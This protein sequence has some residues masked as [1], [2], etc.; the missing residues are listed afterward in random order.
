MAPLQCPTCNGPVGLADTNST[1]T[2]SDLPILVIPYL[3]CYLAVC[4]LTDIPD[5]KGDQSSHYN[6]FAISFGINNTVIIS[7][8]LVLS[9]FIYSLIFRD[10]LASTSIAVCIP[11]FVYAVFRNFQKD[12][13]RAIRYPIAILNLFMMFVYPYLFIGILIIFYLSKYY[14]WHRFNLHYPTFLVND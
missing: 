13:L 5:I 3:L 9:S 10:P 11:F 8:I 6:T 14:Y 12:I 4:L 7:L 1:I 2:F